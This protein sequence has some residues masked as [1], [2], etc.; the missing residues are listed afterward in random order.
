MLLVPSHLLGRAREGLAEREAALAHLGNSV[1]APGATL[2]PT[3]P[4]LLRQLGN[5]SRQ[6]LLDRC[7]RRGS[8]SCI[9][10]VVRCSRPLFPTRTT[11]ATAP[12]TAPALLSTAV[13]DA[14]YLL[15]PWS[16]NFLRPCRSPALLYLPYPCSRP[17]SLESY[18]PTSM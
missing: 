17:P 18:L 8:T 3:S 6:L 9:H 15:L 16:R 14:V 2:T 5:C 4:Q 12:A 7:S 11:S 1:A 13:P 10:A